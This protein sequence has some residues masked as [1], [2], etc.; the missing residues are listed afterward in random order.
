MNRLFRQV[1]NAPLIVF[2]I[3]FGALLALETFGA[4]VT[5]WVRA[6]LVVPTYTFPYI[7]F[8]WLKPLPGNGMYIWFAA[9]GV[10]G[11]LIMLGYRYRLSLGL[12][13]VFWFAAYLMQKAS[14]NNHYY[15]LFL[16]CVIMLLLPANAAMSWD[17]RKNPAIRNDAMPQWC[18]IV[19]VAQIAI[20]YFF[21]ALSKFYP[22]WVNGL[23]IQEMLSVPAGRYHISLFRQHA[24]HVF[25]AYAGIL[26]DLF[27][28]PLFLWR[29][30]RTLA[31]VASL[32]FHLFNAVFLQIGI[33]PFF[34]LS[35]AVFFYPPSRIRALFFRH[36]AEV[37]FV[38]KEWI[39]KKVFYGIFIPYFV[40]QISLPLRHYFI[41]GDVLWTEEGHRLSWRMMLRVRD[42]DLDY[43]I[44]NKKTGE[45]IPYNYRLELTHKQLV[46]VQSKP[47]GIWQMAQHI[48]REFEAKG[49]KVQIYASAWCSINNGPRR[50]L[51]NP[52]VDLCSVKWSQLFHN[53]W[54]TD[55]KG[56]GEALGD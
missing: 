43:K 45:E 22:G 25:I 15:L 53:E 32:L 56:S 50:P 24:F 6:N 40:L 42:G 44:V 37:N 19:M 2:R 26:F 21:A 48:R 34:A 55:Y 17:A 52:D 31:L 4:I 27:I 10:L 39:P 49:I 33:F 46:F 1:D 8:E 5:G 9:M 18:S 47:D 12:F 14:Y 11:I 54:I 51:I 29:K 3:F 30:T 41:K 28:I 38:A 20:V 35:F 13:T 16:I 36:K 7:G 23:F